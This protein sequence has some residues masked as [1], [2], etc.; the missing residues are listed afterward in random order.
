MNY[1]V[2]AIFVITYALVSISPSII[3]C[4]KI[5]KVDIREEGSKNAGATNAL[6]VMGKFWGA[7]VFLLDILKVVVAYFVMYLLNIIFSDLEITKTMYSTFVLAAVVGHS[8]PLYYGL[9][10]G[11]GVTVFLVS[12]MIVDYRA[13]LV[14]LVVA[15]III[16]ITKMVSVGSISGVILA[17]ILA[18]FM[19]TNFDPLITIIAGLIII[20]R[21]KDN[22]VRIINKTETKILLKKDK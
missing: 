20:I 22:I 1:L 19:N 4:K 5:K 7:V 2:I 14:C 3:L 11:K 21:H 13:T 18:T 15:L 12:M 10:G 8:F 17:I 6:R 16:L 9:K